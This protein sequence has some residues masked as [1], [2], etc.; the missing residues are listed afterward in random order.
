M[1]MTLEVYKKFVDDLVAYRGS[2]SYILKAF[3]ERSWES[4]IAESLDKLPDD[5]RSNISAALAHISEATV[6]DTLV[7]LMDRGCELKTS[8]VLIPLRLDEHSIPDDY[9]ARCDGESWEQIG[10]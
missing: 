5:I 4:P 9:L 10:L 7:F 3:K 8:G 1:N 6:H 2:A